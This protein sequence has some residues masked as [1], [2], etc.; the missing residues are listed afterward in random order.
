MNDGYCDCAPTHHPTHTT[1][2]LR[3]MFENM[4]LLTEFNIDPAV[5]KVFIGKIRVGYNLEPTY[6]AGGVPPPTTA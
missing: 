5:F 1:P 6:V 4:H 3:Y 2:P